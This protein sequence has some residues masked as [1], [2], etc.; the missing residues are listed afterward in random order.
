MPFSVELPRD[1]KTMVCLDYHSVLVCVCVCVCLKLFIYF[2]LCWVFV[3]MLG[4][5]LVVESRG[6]SLVSVLGLLVAVA[7]RCGR[8]CRLH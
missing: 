8:A 2:W 3:A 7:S 4:L 5:S 1:S 6:D